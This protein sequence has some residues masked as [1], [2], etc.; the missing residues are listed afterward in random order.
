METNMDLPE[1]HISTV[2]HVWIVWPE[3]LCD[4][5][6]VTGRG[7]RPDSWSK[8]DDLPKGGAFITFRVGD[9]YFSIKTEELLVTRTS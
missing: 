3:M 6:V 7:E 8:R 5:D 4:E 2:D 9:H 1:E